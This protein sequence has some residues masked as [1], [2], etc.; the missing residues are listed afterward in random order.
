MIYSDSVVAAEETAQARA[1]SP[2]AGTAPPRGDVALSRVLLIVVLAI[3]STFTVR[4]LRQSGDFALSDETRHA[5][6]GL[7]FADL[8]ADLPL[9]HP[10]QYTYAYYARYPTLGLIHWPPFFP[11][12]E[13]LMFRAFGPSMTVARLTVLMFTLLGLSFWFLLMRELLG[14]WAAAFAT[15]LLFFLPALFLY[16]QAVMLEVPSL[17]LCLSATYFWWLFLRTGRSREL[18]AFSVMASLAMLTKQQ[19]VYLLPFC[20]L[21]LLPDN[22]WRRLLN[23][24]GATTAAIFGMML[25]PFYILA[26]RTHLASIA[27]HVIQKH[28]WNISDLTFYLRSLPQEIGW[29]LLALSIAG[30]AISHWWS[31]RGDTRLMLMWVI[32]CYLAFSLLNAKQTRYFIYALPPFIY[33]ACWPL[34]VATRFRRARPLLWITCIA[35]VLMYGHTAWAKHYPRLSGYSA[36]AETIIRNS[37]GNEI[38]LFDG[39]GIDSGNLTFDLRLLDREHRIVLL[40]KGLYVTRIEAL[41]VAR[42]VV[43]SQDELQHL[44]AGYGIRQVLISD[45]TRLLFPVQ[46]NLRELLLSPQFKLVA[47]FPL[48]GGDNTDAAHHLLLYENQQATKPTE[49]NLRLPMMTLNH[50]II[51]PLRELGID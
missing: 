13:G 11:L 8:L 41:F 27:D 2:E 28:P 5:M 3:A 42:E 39:S 30:I 47:T 21:T 40:T 48:D 45:R 12:A 9:S 25:A 33:F 37:H 17:A 38:V 1:F 29:P 23:R 15:L 35:L 44:L 46:K 7:Y 32:T 20:L 6:T 51:V 19:C 36:A 22:K 16:E 10:A 34:T 4:G 14:P 43:H 26:I 18:Y 50:D 31:P 49:T 24:R